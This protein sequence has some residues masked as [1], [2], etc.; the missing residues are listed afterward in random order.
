M[1]KVESPNPSSALRW[2]VK[3]LPVLLRNPTISFDIL[4][5]LLP[6]D[7]VSFQSMHTLAQDSQPSPISNLLFDEDPV[8][9]YAEEVVILQ[10]VVRALEDIIST[11]SPTQTLTAVQI[12]NLMKTVPS[13]QRDENGDQMN[14]ES[15]PWEDSTGF[16]HRTKLKLLVSLFEAVRQH[17][18][19]VGHSKE[20]SSHDNYVLIGQFCETLGKLKLK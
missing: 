7:V 15:S 9:D 3:S 17:L 6:P 18:E 12:D 2:F 8:N 14:N 16:M 19:D 1:N 20:L 4:L 11:L 5:S 10:L 13:L